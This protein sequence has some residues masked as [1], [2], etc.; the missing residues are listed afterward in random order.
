L[1]G[2]VVGSVVDVLIGNTARM[3]AVVVVEALCIGSGLGLPNPRAS[4]MATASSAA[5]ASKR[6]AARGAATAV[7][8]PLLSMA[9]GTGAAA[10]G[11][12]GPAGFQQKFVY[13]QP[14][15]QAM[16]TEPL[17]PSCSCVITAHGG[18]HVL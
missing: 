17:Q 14:R 6:T 16:Q 1:V 15:R 18:Q 12:A 8:A 7:L 11:G 9:I 13:Q 5:T 4:W 2:N 3:L 10:A